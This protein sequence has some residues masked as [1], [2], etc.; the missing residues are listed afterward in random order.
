M[1]RLVTCTTILT[2]LVCLFMAGSA[3]ANHGHGKGLPDEPGKFKVGHTTISI[4]GTGTLGESRPIDVEVWYPAEKKAWDTASPS[5]YTSRLNGVTLAP[6]KWDPLSWVVVSEVAR[7]GV[8]FDKHEPFP[9]VIFSHGSQNS[10]LEYAL[11]LEHIASHGYVVVAAW[12]N[13]DTQDDV[14][15]QFINAT[16]GS[17][18]LDCLDHLPPPC[19][20]TAA[21]NVA[22]RARD[23]SA[24]LDMLPVAFGESVDMNQVVAMGH[25]RGTLTSLGAAGGSKFFGFAAEP[26]V[27]AVLGFAAAMPALIFNL[28]LSLITVPTVLVAGEADL[29]TPPTISETVFG[30]ISSQ[31]KAFIIIKNTHHRHFASGFCPELQA[32]GSV[33]LADPT[34]AILDRHTLTGIV[35]SPVN[36]SAVDICGFDYF[37][38]PV[39][40]RSLITFPVGFN[41][42]PESVP[43]QGIDTLEVHRLMS[44]IAVAFFRSVSKPLKHEDCDDNTC[45]DVRFNRFL[46]EKFLLKKEPNILSA[47]IV[48][49]EGLRNLECGEDHPD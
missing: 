31:D 48:T 7:E 30:T 45:P 35:N 20:D 41:V 47:A 28:D 14:R 25:S 33:V 3:A 2:G 11:T 21:K 1:K 15:V 24:V 44:E 32:S 16:N 38:T 22:D 37:T 26:R 17:K 10:P 39:D 42:T 4:V 6:A 18:V 43:T 36:G 8:A 49:D 9:V 46:S 34:R 12:Y 13:G 27:K 29:N 40:V 5:E 23:L 19:V